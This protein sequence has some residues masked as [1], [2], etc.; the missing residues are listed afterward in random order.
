MEPWVERLPSHLSTPAGERSGRGRLSV[1]AI[2]V[3]GAI[4]SVLNPAAYIQAFRLL[5][6]YN[7]AHVQQRRKLTLGRG[8]TIAPNVSITNGERIAVGAGTKVGERC[9]LWAGDS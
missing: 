5:H 1:R 9:F 3:I 6:Y 2:R 4:R 8:A 7:Y